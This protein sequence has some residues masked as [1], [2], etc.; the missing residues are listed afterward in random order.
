MIFFCTCSPSP[1]PSVSLETPVELFT[2]YTGE[3][4]RL[5]CPSQDPNQDPAPTVSWTK[6]RVALVDDEH[7]WLRNGQ[8]VIESLEL[9]DSGLYSCTTF[10]NSSVFFNVTGAHLHLQQHQCK[11]CVFSSLIG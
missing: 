2:R 4:L 9:S 1:C 3:V 6:D 5:S 8:L 10:G 7:T 11:L